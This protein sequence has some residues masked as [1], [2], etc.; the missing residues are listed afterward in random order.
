M[1]GLLTRSSAVQGDVKMKKDKRKRR[2]QQ[3]EVSFE[4]DI[5]LIPDE[6]EDSNIDFIHTYESWESQRMM[7]ANG[8][9]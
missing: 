1:G 3:L 5:H 9:K 7:N 2:L 4:P 8:K 6:N